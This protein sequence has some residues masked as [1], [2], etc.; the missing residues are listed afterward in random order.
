MRSNIKKVFF[1]Y[2]TLFSILISYILFLNFVESD[3]IKFN[4]HNPR[5]NEIQQNL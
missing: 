1:F 4:E 2:L 3:K 5:L